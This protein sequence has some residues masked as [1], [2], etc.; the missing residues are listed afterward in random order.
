MKEINNKR[1]STMKF[2]RLHLSSFASLVLLFGCQTTPNAPVVVN[3]ALDEA[4]A[5]SEKA[6]KREPL[7][8]VPSFVQQEL[9]Q[10][11]MQRAKQGLLAE[12]RLEI[13]ANQV[14]AQDFFAAIVDDSPYSIAV[15]PDV[16][17]TIT[18]NLKDVTLNEVLDVV[19][20]L[21]GY[22]IQRN[23]KIIQ[24]YS[25]GMR[26]ETIPLNYLFVT[27]SGTSNTSVNSGGVSEND[28]SSGGSNGNRSGGSSNRNSN[29]SSNSNNSNGSSGQNNQNSSSGTNIYTSNESNYWQE[30]KENLTAY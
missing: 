14:A 24:V 13:A 27:R 4:I 28:P 18:L 6:V 23:G 17:G 1:K 19:E 10:Q 25:A 29:N 2:S 21:F 5:E 30:L 12:K 20:D 15:H 7:T 22:D 9:M 3:N 11:T 26:T 8:Q 16:S